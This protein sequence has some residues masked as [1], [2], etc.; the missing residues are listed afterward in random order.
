MAFFK[1]VFLVSSLQREKGKD[2]SDGDR[3]LHF[4]ER[5]GTAHD[6]L[7]AGYEMVST[8][9]HIESEAVMTA[10]CLVLSAAISASRAALS[11]AARSRALETLDLR[12]GK[13]RFLW[14]VCH[15]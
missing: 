4:A 12:G 3:A 13:S 7:E 10:T 14:F 1:H 15:V 6:V 2:V 11:A 9:S 8:V 5:L